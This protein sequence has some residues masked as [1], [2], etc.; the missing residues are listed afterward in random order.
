[1]TDIRISDAEQKALIHL[2]DLLEKSG[3]AWATEQQWRSH[4]DRPELRPG[5]PAVDLDPRA[6]GFRIQV[7]I[8]KELVETT[9]AAIHAPRGGVQLPGVVL[10]RPPAQPGKA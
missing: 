4:A 8:D 7:M 2:A 1:M 9:T 6:R 10:Y 5:N 3:S